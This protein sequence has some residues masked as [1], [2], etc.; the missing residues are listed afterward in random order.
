V[1]GPVL[2]IQGDG[3]SE[4]GS[5]LMEVMVSMAIASVVTALIT[6]SMVQM[7]RMTSGSEIR[8]IAQSSVGNA[9]LRI[10]R[11][12]RYSSGVGVEYAYGG[13]RRIEYEV[14]EKDRVA[15]HQLRLSGQRLQVRSWTSG[16]ASVATP[17]STLASG[18]TA[19]SFTTLQP[20]DVWSHQ[21]LRVRLSSG[22]D[23]A[24]RSVD[25]SFTAL[26]TDPETPTT[27]P[28]PCADGHGLP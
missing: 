21:R 18:L 26:N 5:S 25:V 3:E 6:V 23:G 4:G 1:T 14:L 11:Q 2:G 15:C 16:F 19:G 22:A 17:W 27:N 10:D 9:L 24:G 20:D 28:A 13:G 7:F 12:V 8:S